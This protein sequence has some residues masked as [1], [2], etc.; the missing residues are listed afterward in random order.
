MDI[1]ETI[2]VR[3]TIP[4][5]RITGGP[6]PAQRA[7]FGAGR[8]ESSR[9]TSKEATSEDDD[10]PTALAGPGTCYPDAAGRNLLVTGPR[11]TLP[12]FAEPTAVSGGDR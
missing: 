9:P 11:D 1:S 6:A 3:P 7:L 12:C 5:T 8:A 2:G 10:A 4:D